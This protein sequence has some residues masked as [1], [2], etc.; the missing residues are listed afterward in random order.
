MTEA[1]QKII[2]L[3]QMEA[4]Q[5][6]VVVGIAGGHGVSRRL[7]NMGV[8]TGRKITKVSGMFMGGPVTV[9]VGQT[10]AGIGFGMASKIMVELQR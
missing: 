3:T 10:Q 6:G 8:I 5:G 2:P 7:E 9:R 4:G 1:A